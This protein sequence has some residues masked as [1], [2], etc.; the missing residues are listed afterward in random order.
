MN[1][2]YQRGQKEKGQTEKNHGD[3]IFWVVDDYVE[4][5]EGE[6]YLPLGIAS[7]VVN[8]KETFR[9]VCFSVS[10]LLQ[11]IQV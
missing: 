6:M 1:M 9:K 5:Y 10:L 8:R 11:R 4:D 2:I 7:G 3:Y